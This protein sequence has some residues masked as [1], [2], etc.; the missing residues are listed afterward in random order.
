ML[1]NIS[2]NS[3]CCRYQRCKTVSHVRR[4]IYK[5]KQCQWVKPGFHYPS[6][7]P[8]LTGD[9]SPLPVN[10]G[11]VDGRPVSTSQ[12]D[13]PC[14]QVMETGHPSTRLVETGLKW[15]SSFLTLWM[16]TAG[17]AVVPKVTCTASKDEPPPCIYLYAGLYVTYLWTIHDH[18]PEIHNASILFVNKRFSVQSTPFSVNN[19]ASQRVDDTSA[20]TG[21]FVSLRCYGKMSRI[22]WKVRVSV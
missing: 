19:V 16:A 7:W 10:T 15:I 14:W 12:V 5:I 8:E 13:G 22:K 3:S 4:R 2:I 20:H 9:W 11:H 18:T 1:V 21:Y 17:K 6:W